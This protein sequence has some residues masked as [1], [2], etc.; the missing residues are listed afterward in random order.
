MFCKNCGKEVR[1]DAEFC[2]E[3][4]TRLKETSFTER[5]NEKVNNSDE[6]SEDARRFL[7]TDAPVGEVAS[8]K[9]RL[10]AALLAFFLGGF[11]AHEF[12]LG[13]TGVGIVMLI[14]CW[15]GVVEIIAFV[16]FIIILCGGMKDKEG[17][18]V[19][20]W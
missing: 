20:K 5:V 12:Y 13:K 19:V 14:F 15:T 16:Q 9:S 2:P 1:D 8:E 18:A 17:K 6:F 7:S 11:G 10:C 4:G 3:C